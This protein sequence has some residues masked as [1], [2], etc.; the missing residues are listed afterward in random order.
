MAVGVIPHCVLANTGQ[1]VVSSVVVLWSL[2]LGH[3][4]R[5]AH[6]QK[7]KEDKNSGTAFSPAAHDHRAERKK[8]GRRAARSAPASCRTAAAAG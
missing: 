7:Q 1:L 8:E 5:I 2:V 4:I 3:T 6:S